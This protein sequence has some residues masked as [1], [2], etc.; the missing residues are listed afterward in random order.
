MSLFLLTFV[1]I[2]KFAKALHP[3]LVFVI[4]NWLSGSKDGQ[5]H[6]YCYPEAIYTG[7]G[8]FFRQ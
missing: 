3:T 7:A 4:F 5:W 1:K 2:V 6:F 8:Y